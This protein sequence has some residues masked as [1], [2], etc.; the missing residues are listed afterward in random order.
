MAKATIAQRRAKAP[1]LTAE[2]ARELLLYDP[3]TGALT[4]RVARGCQ[5]GALAGTR[6][7]DGYTQVEI[8][9]RLY[10]AHRVIWLM[11]TGKWPKHLL[12]HRNGMRADNRWK[13]LREATHL[14]NSRNRRPGKA[15]SS[16]TVGVSFVTSVQRWEAYIGLD[17]RCITLG[18]FADKEEAI[19]A[20]RQ[21]ELHHFGEFAAASSCGGTVE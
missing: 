19:S 6:T 1:A 9:Y 3:E 14:Q 11:Q 15:N 12:D 18:R 21:A 10:R 7:A 5:R 2:R 20:R 8:D 17:S 16:G 4:W 13:N